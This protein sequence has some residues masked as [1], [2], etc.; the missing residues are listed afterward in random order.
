VLNWTQ[1]RI[2]RELFNTS[3]YYYCCYYYYYCHKHQYYYLLCKER[4]SVGLCYVH[5]MWSYFRFVMY[6]LYRALFYCITNTAAVTLC[7]C[8]CR[9]C[10]P[11]S[12]HELRW[13]IIETLYPGWCVNVTLMTI[14]ADRNMLQNYLMI[15]ILRWRSFVR[16]E[17][18]YR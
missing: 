5:G 4:F 18:V 17:Q 3:L 10:V 2:L 9:L 14:R 6:Y 1:S 13:A 16:C 15:C 7:R 11:Q 8:W 12:C